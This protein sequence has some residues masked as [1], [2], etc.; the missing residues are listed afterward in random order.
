MS[1]AKDLTGL[2]VGDLIVLER[3]YEYPKTL[4]STNPSTY[5]KCQCKCGT[6]FPVK[7]CRLTATNPRERATCCKQCAF[8]KKRKN[9]LDQQF[10]RWSVISETNQKR[11]GHFLWKCQCKCGTIGFIDEQHLLSGASKSCG[12][13]LH[14]LYCEDLTGQQ[15]EK[16]TVIK[17]VPRPEH[18]SNISR[19]YWLCQCECGNQVIVR[20]S[21]LKNHTINSCGCIASLGEQKILHILKENHINYEYQKTF[22]TCY[23]PDTKRCA[24]FDFYINNEF[25]LEFDGK[26]HYEPIEFFGGNEKFELQKTYDEI[27]NLWC[28][29]NHIKLK[30]IPYWKLKTLCLEDILGDEFIYEQEL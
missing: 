24:R 15:F 13:L 25:L 6:I 2:I 8:K 20:A 21:S 16:L 11:G 22:L 1:R 28:K 4:Q 18:L 19:A 12:C 10:G 5:W 9:L 3:D 7:T 26:Q 23:F 14:D 27:K 17:Q 29:N 30:R